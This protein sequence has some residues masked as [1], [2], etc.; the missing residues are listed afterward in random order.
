[1][2]DTYGWKWTWRW[3]WRQD[4]LSVSD[5]TKMLPRVVLR[6]SDAVGLLGRIR[7]NV[8][9]SVKMCQLVLILIF[10][11]ESLS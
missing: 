8:L 3:T 4:Y 10:S 1:M 11:F 9:S 7:R 2:V 5:R 6:F